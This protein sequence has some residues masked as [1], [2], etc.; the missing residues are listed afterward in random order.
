MSGRAR[1][2]PGFLVAAAFIGPGTVTTA[3]LAG[4]R[5]GFA[6]AWAVL[7]A[8]AATL[9]LQEMS[10]RLG[11]V[12]RVGLGEAIRTGIAN[13]VGRF[14]ATGLALL[15]I[16]FGNAAYQAGNLTGAA[17]GLEALAGGPRAAWVIACALGAAALLMSGAYRLVEFALIALVAVMSVVFVTTAIYLGPDLLQ[18][19]EA[20]SQPRIPAGA[21]LVVL[22]LIGTTVV[23]YN[24]FMHAAAVREKWRDAPYR[25]ALVWA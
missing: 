16:T 17:L 18:L 13:P 11:A 21:G 19:V 2:G 1:F 14:L 20:V 25:D 9:I 15:G 23:P 22:A 4:A 24:L 5:Y 6:L 10:A 3:S 12:G 7:A 8:I